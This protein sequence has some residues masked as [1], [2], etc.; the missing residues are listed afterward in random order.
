MLKKDNLLDEE[1]AERIERKHK[2]LS[3]QIEYFKQ[4]SNLN[5]LTT[6]LEETYK[7]F[8]RF[9]EENKDVLNEMEQKLE[10]KWKRF[11][12]FF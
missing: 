2:P 1:L 9:I 6:R 7:S 4:E 3:E 10:L 11:C 12:C 5:K 8:L